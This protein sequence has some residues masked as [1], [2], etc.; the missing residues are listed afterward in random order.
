MIVKRESFDVVKGN[1]IGIYIYIIY[2]YIYIYVH[3]T[4]YSCDPKERL[5]IDFQHRMH[6]PIWKDFFK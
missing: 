3:L 2:I 4:E 5:H 6:W 1:C